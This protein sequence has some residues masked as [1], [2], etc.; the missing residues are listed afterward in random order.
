MRDDGTGGENG[1]GGDGVTVTGRTISWPD[2]GWY[3][4]QSATTYESLC[5]GGTFCEVA[6]GTYHVINLTNGQR[7]EDVRVASPDSE[8]PPVVDPPET[9]VERPFQFTVRIPD[10]DLQFEIPTIGGGYNYS[11]DCDNDGVEEATGVREN[12]LCNYLVAGDHTISISGVFPH[13]YFNFSEDSTKVLSVDQ[14][15]TGQ[16]RSMHKAFAGCQNMTSSAMD[17]PNLASPTDLSYMFY[18]AGT[19]NQDISNW[20][21]SAVTNMRY[22][23][24]GTHSFNQDIGNWDV[25]SVTDMSGMFSSATFNQN[26]GSWDVSSVTSMNRMF[27]LANRFNQDIGSWDV[28]AVTDMSHML[29]GVRSFNQDIGN[30][31][32]SAVTDMSRMF[33]SATSFNQDIGNWDVS[34]VTD[35]SYM[36]GSATSFNQDIGNWNVSAVTDMS[37]MFDRASNFNQDIG[38]WN[39]NAVSDMDGMFDSATSFNQD[40][41]N[42]NVSAVTDMSQMFDHASN[43]N[44]D[45]GNWN[46]SAVTDMDGMFE[47]ANSFNQDI[48]NWN[49]SAVTDMRAMFSRASR[50]NQ[51]IGNWDVSAVT[52]MSSIFYKATLSID[53]YDSL[54]NGWSQRALQSG[55]PFDGGNSSYSSAGAAARQSIIGNYGWRISD[56]GLEP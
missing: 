2:D 41:G 13:L 54:L 27:Y 51:D 37:Q 48:G 4:V 38:N 34:A 18:N 3:Q 10:H 33:G 40:I 19:F 6:P 47:R 46:V 52:N 12:Y 7:Y 11:V 55:V 9:G 17:T 26:I 15:G 56:G 53:N 50:F 30:W 39:V 16:W 36:L 32:V 20:D 29:Y 1:S 45:I 31:D 22:M 42:W 21:V 14:W 5:E 24:V 25:S 35:M 8:E 44:Q 43:F 28:S 23:F 49:V